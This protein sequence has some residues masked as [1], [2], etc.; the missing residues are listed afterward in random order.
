MDNMGG[1][2]CGC[3]SESEKISIFFKLLTMVVRNLIILWPALWDG[4]LPSWDQGKWR[5][6]IVGGIRTKASPHRWAYQACPV[7]IQGR[8]GVLMK[9][10]WRVSSL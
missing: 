3:V 2:Q 1:S 5:V 7:L 9:L 4:P 6:V 10:S 8:L